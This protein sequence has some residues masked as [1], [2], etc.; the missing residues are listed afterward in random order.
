MRQQVR[1][2]AHPNRNGSLSIRLRVT[3]DSGTADIST[4]VTV[5]AAHWDKRRQRVSAECKDYRSLNSTIDDLADQ[6]RA[7]AARNPA[8][9]A[10]ELR[11][12][13]SKP[14]APSYDDRDDFFDVYDLFVASECRRNNWTAGTE[15]VYRSLRA[16]LARFNPLLRLST[17]DSGTLDDFTA[18]LINRGLHNTSIAR[19]I[20]AVHT[21]LRWA[22]RQGYYDGTACQDYRP[23]LPGSHFE[24]KQVIYL[25]DEELAA[26]ETVALPSY[27]ELS[28]DAFIL[29]CYS[30][31]RISDAR[32]LR[33]C[34]I[35]DRAIHI[36]TRKTADNLR[37]E[38]NRH[39]EAIVSKYMDSNAPPDQPLLPL[40][41]PKTL[42]KHI[43]AI[44][45]LCHIDTPIRTVY[46]S[47][48][49]RIEKTVPKWQ[50]VTSHCAR[51]TFVVHALRLG[52]PS[53]V[54][55]RWTGHS[56]LDAMKPYTAIVDSI[57]AES[58]AKFDL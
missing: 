29:C 56:T 57:K 33:Q 11:S 20:H 22:N 51:R 2:V 8:A 47:G 37:I 5:D 58:M 40:Y 25:T 30:G 12:L 41:D 4:G 32:Q 9:T 38:L 7:Y 55:I 27:L 1:T 53:E 13:V 16:T 54:I 52:I 36:V 19:T 26:V 6:L 45:Q 34:D 48:S 3:T 15:A 43:R 39:S 42:N 50:L 35:H 17:F 28:R 44:A 21:F 14:S 49:R 31:L 10:F 23:R 46:F 18:S 24:T